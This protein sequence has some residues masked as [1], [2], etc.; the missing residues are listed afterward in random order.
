[1]KRRAIIAAFGGTAVG[2]PVA[3]LPQPASMPVVGFL[4][5]EAEA[6]GGFRTTAF[7][8]GLEETGFVEGRNVAIE[9]RW[10]DGH[11]ERLPALAADLVQ[12]KVAVICAGNIN[13]A[14]AAQAVGGTTPIVFLTAGDPVAEGL[15]ASFNRPGGRATGVRIFSAGLVA[16][17]LQYLHELVPAATVIG[18]LVNPGNPTGEDQVRNAEAAATVIGLRL[19][20]VKASDERGIDLA[21]ETLVRDKVAAIAVGADPFFNAQ[22]DRVVGLA[23]RHRLPA[24]YEWRESVEAGGLMSY[25]TVLADAFRNLGVYTGR[26]LKGAKPADLPVMQQVKFELVIN[27]GTAKALGLAMPSLLS[28]QADEVI[29]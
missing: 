29:E 10:A 2:W 15:V 7:R 19:Q 26:I 11:R 3:A 8:K 28:A 16:K 6:T 9:Y 23:A 24:A 22:R 13:C 27:A 1:M 5:T 14:L 25:G 21:F 17:R 4:F 20:V 18:F 12:R